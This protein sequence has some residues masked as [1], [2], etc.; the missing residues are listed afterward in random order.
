MLTVGPYWMLRGMREAL[1]IDLVGVRWQPWGKIV[2]FIFI[3]PLVLLYSKLV[4]LVKK[5][6]LFF[7][8]YPLYIIAFLSIAF[9]IDQPNHS[10]VSLVYKV[11]PFSL[12]FCCAYR[13]LP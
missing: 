12:L 7:V 13:L 1:F 6:K 8:I 2:S 10:M 9:F 11:L 4:D 3:I 5:E